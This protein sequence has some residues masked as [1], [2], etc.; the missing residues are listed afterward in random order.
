MNKKKSKRTYNSGKISGLNYFDVQVK[1]E[2]ADKEIISLGNIPVNPIKKGLP[3]GFPWFLHMIYDLFVLLTCRK[4]YLQK[5]WK[6]SKGARIEERVARWFRM[7]IETQEMYVNAREVN[8]ADDRKNAFLRSFLK[9]IKI[10]FAQGDKRVKGFMKI[11]REFG[12]TWSEYSPEENSEYFPANGFLYVWESR[13][14][15]L[16][17]A[18]G[19]SLKYFIESEEREIDPDTFFQVWDKVNEITSKN[20]N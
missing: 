12:V 16:H 11:A 14:G 1:F 13:Q 9:G 15:K 18:H 10:R 7:E 6:E 8:K 20:K 17:F 19:G 3:H 2:K 5:D 4:I